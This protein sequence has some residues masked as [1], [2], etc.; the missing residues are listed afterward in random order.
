MQTTWLHKCSYLRKECYVSIFK[1]SRGPY[2]YKKLYIHRAPTPHDRPKTWFQGSNCSNHR[3]QSCFSCCYNRP[4]EPCGEQCD[5]S[6]AV[7]I[8]CGKNIKI[9]S[10]APIHLPPPPYWHVNHSAFLFS[11]RWLLFQSHV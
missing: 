9:C 6:D 4:L 3:L 11:L 1:H 7:F 5:P 10:I 8:Q 2:L